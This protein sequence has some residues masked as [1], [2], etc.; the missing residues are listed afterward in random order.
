MCMYFKTN[1]TS[2]TMMIKE[3]GLFI[4]ETYE[5]VVK[6]VKEAK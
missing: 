6:K 2:I 5:N 4:N 1:Q 3:N